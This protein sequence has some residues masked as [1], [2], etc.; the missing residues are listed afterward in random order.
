MMT[1]CR[2]M[3]ARQGTQDLV[4]ENS[5]KRASIKTQREKFSNQR[6]LWLV[7]ISRLMDTPSTSPTATNLPKNGMQRT[8]SGRKW[9]DFGLSYCDLLSLFFSHS[10]II[11]L[12]YWHYKLT[13]D[14]AT[15]KKIIEI[16][17]LIK[18]EQYEEAMS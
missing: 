15:K 1:L 14:E 18:K 5:S 13:M 16:R 9:S 6:T 2:F 4:R 17:E 10:T 12:V 7:T 3:R 11:I 8:L